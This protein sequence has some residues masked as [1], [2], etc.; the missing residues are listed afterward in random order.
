MP[1]KRQLV[2]NIVWMASYYVPNELL[3]PD[4]RSKKASRT[5]IK[6]PSADA[7]YPNTEKAAGQLE[8]RRKREI[9]DGTYSYTAAGEA[10]AESWLAEWTPQRNT[11]YAK[12]DSRRVELHFLPFRDFRNKPL[13]S[14]RTEDFRDWARHLRALV[15]QKATATK[16][17]WTIYGVVHA[18]FEDAVI[19]G[20]IPFSAC[21]V[22][23]ANDMP[24]KKKK[25]G[26][27]YEEEEVQELC[28]VEALPADVRVL[29]CLLAF[30]GERVGEGCGHIWAEWD[31]TAAPLTA[32]TLEFQYNRQPLKGDTDKERPRRVPVHGE[33]EAALDWWQREG[34]SAFVGR[35]PRPSDPIIP[36]VFKQGHHS[37]KSVYHRVRDAFDAAQA[38][39]L[40][41]APWKA[42][43][44]LRHA[45]ITA[46]VGRGAPEVWV[47]R[48]THNASGA[49][50]EPTRRQTVG[51]YTHTEW[52]PLCDV[53]ALVPWRRSL[54]SGPVEGGG[55][56]GHTPG[57]TDSE[58]AETKLQ[59]GAGEEIRTPLQNGNAPG[60]T[61]K[62]GAF[63]GGSG[64]SSLPENSAS[65][66][67]LAPLVANPSVVTFDDVLR[68]HPGAQPPNHSIEVLDSAEP[69]ARI[70]ATSDADEEVSSAS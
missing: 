67:P 2:G 28:W 29:L 59:T 15:E 43:H 51:H 11:R 69:S 19:A 7:G 53:V 30:T 47:E 64:A 1:Y 31:R 49:L 34:W 38:A 20:R 56:D 17:A 52:K 55:L 3:P 60:N 8:N 57:H 23:G 26:R 44:A 40:V 62:T 32:L 16:N 27:T 70:T 39:G 13:S 5:R 33:L 12:G 21:K 36:N 45:F 42:H 50:V 6:E 18:M 58:L 22:D 63:D 68:E 25:R 35:A 65:P 61:G 48:V 37:E 10:T 9:A 24:R 4:R 66:E 14:F 54:A 41:Q 46:L